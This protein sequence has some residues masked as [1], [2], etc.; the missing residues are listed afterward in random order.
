MHA[1]DR[2]RLTW[3]HAP[4]R[5][6][7]W[8]SL[9]HQTDQ[10]M[11]ARVARMVGVILWHYTV[12]LTPLCQCPEVIDI[13]R[14]TAKFVNQIRSRWDEVVPGICAADIRILNQHLSVALANRWNN[15]DAPP[16]DEAFLFTDAAGRGQM[17]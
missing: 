1:R 6:E 4:S 15:L 9:I 2:C 10:P 13:L 8:E 16:T 14:R 11:T 12:S 7:K 5:A 3:R 17:G